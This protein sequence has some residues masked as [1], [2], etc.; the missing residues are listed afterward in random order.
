MALTETYT[1][2][3]DEAVFQGHF[4]ESPVFPG[5]LLIGMTRKVI[6]SS[7]KHPAKLAQI[8][9]HRFSGMVKPGDEIKI[10]VK[11]VSDDLTAEQSDET[12]KVI[13][14]TVAYVQDKVVAKGKFVYEYT[15]EAVL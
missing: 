5:V 6:E 1:I 3:K 14:S 12:S 7:L 4:P 8:T 15:A 10:T 11:W 2:A 13:A 9:R